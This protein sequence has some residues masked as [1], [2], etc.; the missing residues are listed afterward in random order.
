MVEEM[1]N[2]EQIR[3]LISLTF[4]VSVDDIPEDAEQNNITGWDSV[5]HLNLMLAI[6]ETFDVRV[7]VQQ[8][9]ELIS[10]PA[11]LAFLDTASDA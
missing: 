9:P 10:V 7:G 8:M 5:G 2:K 11:I 6:E 4:D 3:E 1:T